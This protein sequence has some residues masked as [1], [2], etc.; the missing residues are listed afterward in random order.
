MAFL[1]EKSIFHPNHKRMFENISLTFCPTL[2]AKSISL[3]LVVTAWVS[4]S[5]VKAAISYKLCEGGPTR[6]AAG[7][8]K[9]GP[10]FW[11]KS[12]LWSSR[13]SNIGGGRSPPRSPSCPP[14]RSE[15]GSMGVSGNDRGKSGNF[16]IFWGP[17]PSGNVNE[18]TGGQWC[19]LHK[20]FKLFTKV[21]YMVILLR[22]FQSSWVF[23][24]QFCTGWPLICAQHS[25]RQGRASF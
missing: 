25:H 9:T 20:S 13:G 17:C 14:N 23:Q 16:G 15:L 7:P 8:P 5:W 22:N 3:T 4:I 12:F 24:G 19:L 6:A 2:L 11:D 1:T 10:I 18:P 21:T